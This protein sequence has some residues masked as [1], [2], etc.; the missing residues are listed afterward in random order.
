MQ[1][2]DLK[3]LVFQELGIYVRRGFRYVSPV[4][5]PHHSFL[6]LPKKNVVILYETVE[7]GRKELRMEGRMGGTIRDE[8]KEKKRKRVAPWHP[9][10]PLKKR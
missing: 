4:P 1:S 2:Q 5:T 6:K 7:E 9:A 10:S 8:G 3:Q